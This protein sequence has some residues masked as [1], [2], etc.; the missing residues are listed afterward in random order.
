MNPIESHVVFRANEEMLG[1]LESAQRLELT[2]DLSP[3][4]SPNRLFDLR[5]GDYLTKA[6]L[7]DLPT[8]T[9]SQKTLDGINYF[10]VADICQLLYCIPRAELPDYRAKGTSL[11]RMLERD[12]RYSLKSGLTPPT[13]NITSEFF[14]REVPE[15]LASVKEVEKRIKRAMEQKGSG[16][17]QTQVLEFEDESQIPEDSVRVMGADEEDQS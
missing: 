4:E 1:L 8:I 13:H 2:P 5:L 9:E 16:N 17:V 12:S 7:L 15:S 10:K 11:A 14:K 3:F 6:I